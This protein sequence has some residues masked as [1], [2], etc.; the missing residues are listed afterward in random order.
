MLKRILKQKKAP[1]FV[2][3]LILVIFSAFT[4]YLASTIKMGISSD[5]YY[6]L[7]V[8]QTYSKTLGIPENT[9]ETYQWRD[10]TRVP[11]LPHWINGRI[12]NLNDSFLKLDEVFVL[13]FFN[14][15]CALGTLVFVYLTSKKLIKNK[16]GQILP[17]FLLSNTL[18]FV[19]LSSSINYDNLTIFLASGAIYFLMKFLQRPID[20]ANSLLMFIFLLLGSLT[21]TTTLPLAFII[22]VVWVVILFRR[23]VLRKEFFKQLTNFSNILIFIIFISLVILNLRLYGVNILTYGSLTPSC[24]DMLT[25]E[26]CLENGVFYRNIYKIPKVF[27]G[28]ILDAAK[29]VLQGKRTDPISYIPFWIIQMSKK[30]FGIM[31]DKSLYMKYEFLPFYFVYFFIGIY[32][33]FKNRKRLRTEDKVLVGISVF[34]ALVLLYYHNYKTYITHDW[35]DLALQGRYIFPVLAPMYIVFSRYF[36]KI[37]NKKVLKI[38]TVLLII[39]FLLGNIAYFF[40]NVPSEWFM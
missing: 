4:I 3:V 15:F 5:S 2:L 28:N 9:P 39:I 14:I 19:F 7:R 38:L 6:H 31:G 12:I 40:V 36:L 25:Y 35:R 16:W 34:Y 29:L 20:P 1:K 18:M 32:Q 22:T 8:A 33:V 24:L 37:K 11:Y 21:K 26:Q 23:K 10:I 27:E 13:R 30:I 17:V